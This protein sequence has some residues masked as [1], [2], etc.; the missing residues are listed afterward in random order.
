MESVGGAR[1]DHWYHC[2]MESVGGARVDH[3]YG[4]CRWSLGGSLFTGMESVGGGR[5]RGG[6]GAN[7]GQ[8]WSCGR[9]RGN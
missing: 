4:M 6:R 3:W 1:V 7:T 2:G 9:G 8:R 5:G